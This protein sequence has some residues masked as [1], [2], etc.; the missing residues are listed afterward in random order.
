MPDKATRREEAAVGLFVL[1][2]FAILVATLVSLT[3]LFSRDDVVYHAYFKN[4][5]GLTKGTEVRYA[6]GPAV[7]RV[8][9]VR[10]DPNDSTRMEITF[11]VN[12]TVPVKTDSR[13]AITSNSPLSDNYL[14]VLPGKR[15]SPRAPAGSELKSNEYVGFADL[16]DEIADL[17]PKA[18]E[19]ITNLNSRVVELQT[20]IVRVNDLL[21]D[22]NRA[23]L[24]ATLS[25][26]RGMLEEDRPALHSTLIHVDDATQ[27]LKPLIEDFRKTA[28]QA[29]T[30]LNHLDE[31]LVENR[32]EFHQAIIQLRETLTKADNL[33]DSLDRTLNVNSDNID[34][35]LD[36]IRHAT[37]NLQEFT[38]T[39]K[40][41]PSTLI[42]STQP[43]PR[44][45]G[46]GV[47][48]Q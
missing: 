34:E 33:I 44:K 35:I 23:N 11:R 19:L 14:A 7:G 16:E 15:E 30:T 41:R 48:K 39:I 29:N 4:A 10:S 27:R 18:Q 36:N 2:V 37:E 25:N 40:R 26:V 43:P 5:G 47:D 20:T 13:V 12:P 28:A 9:E 46:Q 6:G 3:G 22:K 45:P 21:N 17:G 38:D 8:K 24:S 32:P 31:T 42:R 1:V